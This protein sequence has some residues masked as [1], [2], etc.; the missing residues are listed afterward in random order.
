MA[1]DEKALHS[2]LAFAF[3]GNRLVPISVPRS[4]GI[5][6]SPVVTTRKIK[7]DPATGELDDRNPLQISTLR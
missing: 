1:A 4:Q 2:I 3:T 5:P 7:V 6:I